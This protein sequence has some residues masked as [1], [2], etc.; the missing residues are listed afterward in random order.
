[1]VSKRQGIIA[2]IVVIVLVAAGLIVVTGSNNK[3]VTNNGPEYVIDAMDRN[4]TT[5]FTPVRIVSA[6]P[7]ITELVYALGAGDKLVAVT[8]YCDYPADVVA[9]KANSSLASIGG[10]YTPNF[11]KVA[12]ATPDLVLLDFS[13]QK[14][15]DMMPQ[16][17]SLGIKYVVMFE[18]TNTTEVYKNI[19]L[20]GGVLHESQNAQNMITSMQQRFASIVTSIGVQASKP[21]VMVAVYYDQSSM[22]IDG[23]Q[24]F[25]DDIITGAG[26]INA[27]ANVS[28]F[29]DVN[30]EAAL[31][32]DPDFI[33]ITATMNSQTPQEVYDMMMNDTLMKD[34]KAVQ[35]HHVYVLINQAENSFL[36]EGIREVQATQILAE[37]MFP[38]TFNITIPHIISDEYLG[39][40][41]SNWN[42]NSTAAHVVM[43]TNVW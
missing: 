30:R 9:R 29:Q 2:V 5:N 37:I 25:I 38:G 6:S 21:K 11:E 1:M 42:A 10:F 32:A 40:L 12:N 33:L 17:D 24:T 18:G 34:T 8:D 26:G 28:G 43:E 36:H 3:N 35:Q 31:A 4:I 27:F 13:V 39:Y 14:D 23:G 20:A 7:T 15:K 41:P 19:E 16:L 22:W